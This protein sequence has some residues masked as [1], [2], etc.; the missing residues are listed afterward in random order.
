MKQILKVYWI[1]KCSQCQS[2]S[3]IKNPASWFFVGYQSLPA[4]FQ[5]WFILK[6]SLTFS[7]ISLILKGF[8][9]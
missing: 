6:I 9:I 2:D 1:D 4:I 8:V 7:I 5:E 3:V